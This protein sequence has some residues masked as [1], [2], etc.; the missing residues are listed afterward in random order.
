MGTSI[1]IDKKDY[2]KKLK[3]K[4]I[5]YVFDKESIDE[6]VKLNVHCINKN[7]IKEIDINTTKYDIPCVKECDIDDDLTIPNKEYKFAI[8]VPNYNNDHG[9]YKDKTYLQ[10]CI[11]SI[12]S[13]TYKNFELIFVDDMSTDTSVKTIQSYKDKR[14]HLIQNKRKKYNGGSRNIGIDYALENID[15]D[16]FAFL[17]SDDWWKDENVLET[18]NKSLYNHELMLLGLECINN[19]GVFLTKIH[20]YDNYED[21]FLSDNKVW[22]TA[23]SRIIRKDKIVHFCEDTMMEDRV[24]S[25]KQADNVDFRKVK[26]LKKVCYVWNRMNTQN[27]VSLKRDDFWNASSFCHIGHQMQLLGQL[28]HRELVPVL[29]KRIDECIRRVNNKIYEQ[30]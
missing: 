30:Y 4:E 21:F 12:L 29:Q 10:N 25:Y 16:Y 15:F 5:V 28:K 9:N 1:A 26:N 7:Y 17:D 19:T 20:K 13:Q 27:S 6:L 3:D 22:C 8:I 11:E 23:W 18:I 2:I 24:W 14:I